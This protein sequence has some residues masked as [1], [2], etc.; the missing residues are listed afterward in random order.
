MGGDTLSLHEKFGKGPKFFRGRPSPKE[1]EKEKKREREEEK[2]TETDTKP[3]RRG[4]VREKGREG[5]GDSEPA[6]S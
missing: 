4:R 1:R 5:W 2:K 6:R 3:G